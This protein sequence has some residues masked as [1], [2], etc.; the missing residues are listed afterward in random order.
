MSEPPETF[1]FQK[2]AVAQLKKISLKIATDVGL[3][4]MPE[5]EGIRGTRELLGARGLG[6]E[7]RTTKFNII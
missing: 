7:A 1:E 4:W 5:K 2:M 6:V 3:L